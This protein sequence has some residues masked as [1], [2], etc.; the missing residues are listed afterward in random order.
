MK[1]EGD[2]GMFEVIGAITFK[3]M[4]GVLSHSGVHLLSPVHIMCTRLV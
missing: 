4:G 3:H 2:L 1:F